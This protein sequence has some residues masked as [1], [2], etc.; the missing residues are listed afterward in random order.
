[1]SCPSARIVDPAFRAAIEH[2]IEHCRELLNYLR[3]R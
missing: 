2:D 3:D 1:V